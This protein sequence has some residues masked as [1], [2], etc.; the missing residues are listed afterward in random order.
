MP[1]TTLFGKILGLLLFCCGGVLLASDADELRE[2][3]KAL[4]KK[5][6]ISAQQ[7]KPDQAERL[8]RE[9]GELMEAAERMEPKAI[10]RGDKRDRPGIDKEVHQLKWRLQDLLAKEREM[11]EAKAPEQEF[12]E[13]REQI[14]RIERELEKIHTH[15]AGNDGM[16]PE[17]RLQAEKLGVASRR[18]HHIRVAAQN[19]KMA[20]EH[21]LAHKLMEK[22]EDMERDLQESKRRLA[23]DMQH[24]TDGEHK[25]DVVQDMRAEIERLRAEVKELNQK[26]EKR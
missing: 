21:D 13:V 11:R 1:R 6:S 14:A 18:I 26:I 19:L 3:A 8:E 16:R 22:S 24:A 17:F 15:H 9:S 7:G 4:R 2:R 5:A 10:G 12:G 20:E 25:P 23:V